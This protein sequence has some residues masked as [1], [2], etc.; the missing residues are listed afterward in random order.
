[1]PHEFIVEA[2]GDGGGGGGGGEDVGGG[3]GITLIDFARSALLVTTRIRRAGGGALNCQLNTRT[4]SG[5]KVMTATTEHEDEEPRV[6]VGRFIDGI[7]ESVV[8]GTL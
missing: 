4:K 8:A 3:G 2:D 1:M 7:A 5:M 6:A